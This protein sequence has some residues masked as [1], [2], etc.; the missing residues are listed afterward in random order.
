MKSCLVSWT[1]NGAKKKTMERFRE[2][3]GLKDYL[4]YLTLKKKYEAKKASASLI[5]KKKKVNFFLQQLHVFDEKVN[6][7]LQL[8]CLS[9]LI[10]I[11]I[12]FYF[13]TILD[14]TS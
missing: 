9:G 11:A 6:F 14:H 7:T 12:T 10:F 13:L 8:L 3:K 2:I 5:L 1:S 4:E